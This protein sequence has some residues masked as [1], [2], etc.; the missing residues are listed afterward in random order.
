MAGWG[1]GIGLPIAAIGLAF[2]AV[3]GFSPDIALIGEAPNTIATI[4][5]VIGY[6]GLISLWNRR[7]T[8]NLHLRVRAAGRMAL[9]NY[10]TQTVLGI[11]VLRG[12]F[13]SEA[14]NR[15]WIAL[16]IVAVWTLQLAW[17]KP[18]LDRFRFGPLEWAW[19][20]A[21]YRNLQ[22]LRR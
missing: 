3:N 17:S 2:Q 4:P 9:T 15:S 7:A 5:M 8:K 6:V 12:I 13:N 20:S 18:W 1:L 21:T 11:I 22:P 16:F 14:L 19:R 10:L